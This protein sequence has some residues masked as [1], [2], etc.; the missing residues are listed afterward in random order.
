[1]LVDVV[2]A[3]VNLAAETATQVLVREQIG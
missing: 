3:H 2:G 1:V